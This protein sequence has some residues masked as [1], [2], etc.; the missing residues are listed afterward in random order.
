MPP[1]QQPPARPW[2]A[3]AAAP[4]LTAA[5]RTTPP[6]PRRPAVQSDELS[7]SESDAE[8]ESPNGKPRQRWSF[9]QRR[10]VGS[11]NAARRRFDFAAFA[12]VVRT[13]TRNLNRIIDN[14]YYPVDEARNSNMRHRPVGLG[15]QARAAPPDSPAPASPFHLPPAP[16]RPPLCGALRPAPR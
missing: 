14:N 13:A 2:L 12:S 1:P 6:P 15:V 16:A 8:S 11:L 9:P 4:A 10:L 7:L 5:P 3:G